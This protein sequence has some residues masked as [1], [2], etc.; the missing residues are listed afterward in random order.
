MAPRAH[1][2]GNGPQKKTGNLTLN[3][4]TR[5]GGLNQQLYI[6]LTLLIHIIPRE[7]I[8]EMMIG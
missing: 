4:V 8:R 6:N 5:E 1:C 2:V 3:Q 7:L